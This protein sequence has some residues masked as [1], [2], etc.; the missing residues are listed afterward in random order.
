VVALEHSKDA[1]HTCNAPLSSV[2]DI[3]SNPTNPTIPI[4]VKQ[5]RPSFTPIKTLDVNSSR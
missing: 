3:L 1:I 2:N 5:K 4:I